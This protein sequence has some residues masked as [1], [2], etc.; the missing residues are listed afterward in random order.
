MQTAAAVTLAAAIPAGVACLRTPEVQPE[1]LQ[2]P[3]RLKARGLRKAAHDPQARPGLSAPPPGLPVA[4]EIRQEEPGRRGLQQAGAC[5]GKREGLYRG[6][7]E[8]WEERAKAGLSQEQREHRLEPWGDQKRP[9]QNQHASI[10][11]QEPLV[12]LL[13]QK[14]APTEEGTAGQTRGK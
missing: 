2:L 6:E 5:P 7:P 4:R 10:E 3:P 9:L 8:L 12:Q 11:Q 14:L 1:R 13:R